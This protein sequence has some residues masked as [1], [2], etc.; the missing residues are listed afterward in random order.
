MPTDALEFLSWI[1]DGFG[2]WRYLISPAFRKRTHDRWKREGWTTAL[3]DILLGSL[4]VVFTLFL[5]SLLIL[6][7]AGKIPG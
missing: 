4:A 5:L 3:I 1:I 7:L 2:G 6:L